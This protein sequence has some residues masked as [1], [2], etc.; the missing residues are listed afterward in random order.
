M[1]IRLHIRFS[2]YLFRQIVL[3]DQIFILL[4]FTCLLLL[5]MLTPELDIHTTCY[6]RTIPLLYRHAGVWAGA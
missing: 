3:S 6:T 1:L 2:Q 5:F 4:S